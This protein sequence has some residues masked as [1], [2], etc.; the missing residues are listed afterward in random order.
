[1]NRSVSLLFAGALLVFSGAAAEQAEDRPSAYSET[2]DVEVVNVD[3][4]V[5]DKKGNPVT[6]LTRED[7]VLLADKKRIDFEYFYASGEA[8]GA[9]RQAP[10]ARDPEKASGSEWSRTSAVWRE[11]PHIVVFVDN[12]NIAPASRNRVIHR[13]G[14]FLD[15]AT[16]QGSR[17]MLV[18]NDGSPNIRLPFTDDP[19]EIATALEALEG[20]SIR[21]FDRLS[22]R[23]AILSSIEQLDQS[24]FQISADQKAQEGAL[25]GSSSE[26]PQLL[27]SEL[28]SI[29]GQ[30]RMYAETQYNGIVNTIQSLAG[31]I[32]LLGGLPGRKAIVHVSDGLA[33]RPGQEMI[34]ALQDSYQDGQRLARVSSP[35]LDGEETPSFSP[36]SISEVRGLSGEIATFDATP[37]YRE[38]VARANAGRVSFYTING[39]GARPA[40]MDAEMSGGEAATFSG[41][42]SGFQSVAASSDQEGIRLMADATG[43]LS[44]S[45]AGVE[46]FLDRL[47]GDMASYYS[48]GFVPADAADTGYHRLEVKLKQKGLTVRHRRGYSLQES[49]SVAE[50]T[51]S[52]LL[53]GFE[54]NHHGIDLRIT[55][56]E[57]QEDESLVHMLLE[58]PIQALSLVPTEGLH[59][60]GGM[61]YVV[62]RPEGG[63]LSP[64]RKFPFS[65]EIPD[66]E[67][68]EAKEGLW[69]I[70]MILSLGSGPH[71][72][73]VAL[74]DDTSGGGSIVRTTVDVRNWGDPFG[75]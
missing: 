75:P 39:A 62:S 35:G 53:L 3:V 21:G 32:D 45:G 69:G 59:V 23:R 70:Q 31:F 4:Y 34:Y 37:Q 50:R 24:L 72:V 1:M 66:E 40:L 44:L 55:K 27:E 22:E 46:G 56:Q 20:L 33:V 19:E 14:D 71:N 11:P 64:L 25:V 5:S 17:V 13:L 65:F 42:A 38:M 9:Q 61:I 41:S 29:V 36:S 16:D 15:Q 8:A 57:H 2:V 12:A 28:A 60:A 52:A 73:A 43:G 47:M 67:W 51:I 49:A 18:T 58:V 6:D 68:E 26:R 10:A 74:S 48:L 7:F 63:E 54:D 30:V